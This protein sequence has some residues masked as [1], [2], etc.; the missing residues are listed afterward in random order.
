MGGTDLD[1]PVARVGDLE[2]DTLPPFVDADHI[3]SEHQSTRH[4]FV[5]EPRLLID[6]LG[7]DARRRERKE[8]AV[9]RKRQVVIDRRGADWVVDGDEED[10]IRE[11]AFDLDLV[12]EE[13]NSLP[14]KRSEVN[15][16][17][18][19]EI[20][21]LSS[22]AGRGRVQGPSCLQKNAKGWV[23]TGDSW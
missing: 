1:G 15:N 5:L 23:S 16:A 14:D 8:R 22:Q 20:E 17:T 3:L 11:G 7:K 13:R 19:R 12:D 10:A 9:E 21:A 18:S 6:A 2:P 4:L